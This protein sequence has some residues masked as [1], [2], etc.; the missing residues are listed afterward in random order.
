MLE[1][2]G[3]DVDVERIM[4]EI[5]D[6]VARRQGGA[7]TNGTAVLFSAG[8]A[9]ENGDGLRLQPAFQPKVD[10]HYHVNDLL[11]FHG[12]EFLRNSYVAVLGREPDE[13]GLAKHLDG[14]A[15]GR[16]NKLDVLASLH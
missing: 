10:K 2:N 15:S 8:Q 1:T 16:F 14:L 4:Y 13:I 12:V 9:V 7:A 11:R 6:A 5:R 3:A